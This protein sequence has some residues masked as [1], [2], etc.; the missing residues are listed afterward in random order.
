[1]QN[2]VPKTKEIESNLEGLV[3]EEVKVDKDLKKSQS[4]LKGMLGKQKKRE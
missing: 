4:K 3:K 2:K 1:M